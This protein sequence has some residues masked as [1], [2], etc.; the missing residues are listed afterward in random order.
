MNKTQDIVSVAV[1][2]EL[3]LMSI[4]IDESSKIDFIV[5]DKGKVYMRASLTIFNDDLHSHLYK[6]IQSI[7]EDRKN[8]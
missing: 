4:H 6:L 8:K 1:T 7:L 3:A 2:D 5:G